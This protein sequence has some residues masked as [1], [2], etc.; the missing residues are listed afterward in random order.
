MASQR[1]TPLLRSVRADRAVASLSDRSARFYFMLLA[2]VDA[3]GR[4][5]SDPALL[6]ADVWPLAR[7]SAD[8]VER[9]VKDC[10]VAGLIQL[11]RRDRDAWIQV[12][13]WDETHGAY[14]RQKDRP[15]SAFP[16]PVIDS[17]AAPD[18]SVDGAPLRPEDP[19]P[20]RDEQHQAKKSSST[21]VESPDDTV[22]TDI[23]A[24]SPAITDTHRG[25]TAAH[26][27]LISS[28][29]SR[30]TSPS[31][32]GERAGPPRRRNTVS[33]SHD[34][35]L[36]TAEFDRVR[37]SPVIVAAWSRWLAHAGQ[38]GVKAKTPSGT[39]AQAILRRALGC[40]AIPGGEELFARAVDDAIANN[41]QG[42]NPD[43]VRG[44]STGP[45]SVGRGV[46]HPKHEAAN[47]RAIE[48]MFME[49]GSETAIPSQPGQVG[50][51]EVLQ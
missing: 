12:A 48:R 49:Q 5:T 9:C 3:Y 23:H 26:S 36:A 13:N 39:T 46:P 22:S 51:V 7:S 8:E 21:L 32:E 35:V 2:Q 15:R 41:W 30:S 42:V 28:S 43:W 4:I 45:A 10:T 38:P 25:R 33:L 31:S 20:P 40:L 16:D 19:S 34:E 18:V 14:G 29:T 11:H 6:N 27:S 44:G 47:R 24:N 50:A 1:Y 17:R 37:S